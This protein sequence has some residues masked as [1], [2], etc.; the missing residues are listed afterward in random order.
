MS[1]NVCALDRVELRPKESRAARAVSAAKRAPGM[2]QGPK[3]ARPMNDF[4]PTAVYRLYAAEDILLYVGVTSDIELRLAQH[5]ETQP[6]WNHVVRYTVD[7]MSSRSSALRIEA[8]WIA[9]D[10]PLYNV[11]H[12]R[13]PAWKRDQHL[14]FGPPYTDGHA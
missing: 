1:T 5:A 11:E 6:W 2:E 8:H 9:Q 14:Q 10:S 4:T 7:W 3:E 12:S 13:V